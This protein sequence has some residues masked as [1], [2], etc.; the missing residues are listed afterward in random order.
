MAQPHS[1]RSLTKSPIFPVRGR[2]D[3]LYGDPRL[4]PTAT[5]VMT[6]VNITE[7]G[8]AR[9]RKG[10]TNYNATQITESSV[11]KDVVGLRQQ[12]FSDGTTINLEMAGTKVYTDDGT[13]RT[14]ITGSLTLTD[15]L[16]SRCRFEFIKDQVVVTNG[17]DETFVYNGSGNATALGGVLWTACGDVAV[18]KNL[19]FVMNTVEGGTRYPTRL[20]WC[21]IN[22]TTYQL[23]ITVWPTDQYYEVYDGGAPILGGVE[24]FNR[25]MIVKS[26]G[27]YPVSVGNEE[28]FIEAMA[29]A[30]LRGSF[31]PVAP[32]SIIARPEFLWVIAED[33]AYVVRPDMSFELITKD[34]QEEWN[35]LNPT[36]LQYAHSWVREK[37][38]QVRTLVS[39]ASNTTGHDVILVW[40]WQTG[41]I[42]IDKPAKAMNFASS[43]RLSNLEYDMFG[44]TDGYVLKGNDVTAISDGGTDISWRIK[45][46][47]NDLGS[48]GRNKQIV[49]INTFVKTVGGSQTI[50]FICNRD[51]GRELS[52][53]GNITIGTSLT[54][55]GGVLWDSG[56]KWDGN[57][58]DVIDFFVNR[59]AET[60]APEWSGTEDFELQGYQVEYYIVD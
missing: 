21:D 1:R 23:D 25:L 8:T 20:R 11:A 38:H 7:R 24:A 53:T 43:W 55:D 30:P 18:H 15:D 28:G 41:D 45:M 19:L 32:N 33:G 42:F 37:D 17:T 5:E 26:D 3:Y 44:T 60:I 52:R 50:E 31:S 4:D 16:E 40:D 47:P 49:L 35:N 39:S 46:K 9:K 22:L 14:D 27:I 36:R 34:I 10:Y 12:K 48:P 56:E 57:Q 13:T 59:T 58:S 29:E 6:N 51:Q 2:S 54:W